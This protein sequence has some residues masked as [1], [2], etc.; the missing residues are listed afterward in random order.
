MYGMA[1]Y[2]LEVVLRSG[3]VAQGVLLVII[4]ILTVYALE[5]AKKR[6]EAIKVRK[7]PAI[8]AFEE[9]VGRAT[10][11]GR[12]VFYTPGMSGLGSLTTLSALSIL[13]Y[14]AR[15]TARYNVPII[16]ANRNWV[17]YQVAEGI[18]KNAYLAEGKAD[19]FN[20]EMVRYI[21]SWQFAFAAGC[22]GIFFRERPAANF[23]MGYYYAESLELAESGYRIGAV[24]IA[25][26]TSTAQLPFF[27]AACDYVLIGEELY[28]AAAFLARD[29][30]IVGVLLAHDLSKILTLAI[31]LIGAI[32]ITAGSTIIL[33]ILSK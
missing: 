17:V 10:E 7:I 23:Y 19:Q 6:P 30:K 20:P 27:V 26:T 11:M 22:L 28:A 12:P 8:D 9:A 33:D 31:I 29:P 32:A 4:G 5:K 25:G 21:A 15:L 16:V 3:R 14:V 24:Q 18:V 2:Q 13:D 1:I